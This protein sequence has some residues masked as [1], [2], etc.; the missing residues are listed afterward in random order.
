MDS[1]LIILQISDLHILAEPGK[2]MAGV[3][4]EQTFVKML[5]HI[6]NTHSKIDLLLVTGDLAEEPCQSSYQRIYQAHK[7]YQTRTICLP[8]NHDNFDL[9][10]Q[11]FTGKQINCDKQLQFKHWQIINLNSQKIGSAGGLL[12]ASELDFLTDT[13]D[14]HPELN[15]LIAVHHPPVPTNSLWM[16]T[17]MIENS[18]ELFSQLKHYPQVTAISC[19]HI[20]QELE[21]IKES[22]L[23]LGMPS[24][25]FQFKP[26]SDKY[27][28]DDREPGYRI[29]SLHANGLLESSIHRL[30]A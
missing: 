3:D 8:G 2:T 1:P 21:Q 27:A 30:P 17:M 18:D 22:K 13:L 28:L 12:D 16:D 20:H 25:C 19:G 29:F 15:A 4:T 9:M 26:F 14:S 5:E 24:T 23:I 10:R 7:K 11:I 6:H